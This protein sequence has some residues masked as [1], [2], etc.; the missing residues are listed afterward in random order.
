MEHA[1]RGCRLLESTRQVALRSDASSAPAEFLADHPT[2]ERSVG[3][4]EAPMES[5]SVR[6]FGRLL[7]LILESIDPK[8]PEGQRTLEIL[9][10]ELL[11]DDDPGP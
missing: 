7:L 10:R 2:P 11:I 3:G 6:Q 9:A 8:T 5:D 4:R 1:C